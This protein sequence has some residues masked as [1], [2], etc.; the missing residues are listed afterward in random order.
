MAGIVSISE[1]N[2]MHPASISKSRAFHD[3]SSS[4]DAPSE[5]C[6]SRHALQILCG[7]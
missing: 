4:I 6:L 1:A 2:R 7:G 3:E 5:H